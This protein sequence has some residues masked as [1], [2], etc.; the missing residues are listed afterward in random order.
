[1]SSE[2][3]ERVLQRLTGSDTCF[4]IGAGC[5]RC[6]GKPLIGELTAKVLAPRVRLVVA[7]FFRDG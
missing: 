6:A 2:T 3:K 5:S 7:S 4:L 1:M